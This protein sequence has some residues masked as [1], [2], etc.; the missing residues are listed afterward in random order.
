MQTVVKGMDHV[1]GTTHRIARIRR[2]VYVVD[3]ILDET[4]QSAKLSWMGRLA[5]G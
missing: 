2:D 4:V 5:L 3:R 1:A